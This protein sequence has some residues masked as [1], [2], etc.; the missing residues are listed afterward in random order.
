MLVLTLIAYFWQGYRE[1][2]WWT[3]DYIL[4]MVIPFAVVP[5][6]VWFMFVPSLFEFSDSEITIKFP[7]RRVHILPWS[8][9]QHY[10]AG[11]NVFMIQF[12]GAGTFQMF[13][14]AFPGAEWRTLTNFLSTRFPERKPVTLAIVCLDGRGKRP[15]KSLE[16]TA[17]RSVAL[18]Q[19][20]SNT[21]LEAKL[22]PDS[23]GSAPSRWAW[24]NEDAC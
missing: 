14:Q 8:D 24:G 4:T 9:L 13:A 20:T 7:F 5:V 19:M 2:K 3:Q 1:N 11:P 23:G 16:P 6:V 21:P 17:G 22:A 12:A 15:N 10:G 18:F